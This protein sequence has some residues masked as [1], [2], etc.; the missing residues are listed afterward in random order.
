MG[1]KNNI[2]NIYEYDNK[3]TKKEQTYQKRNL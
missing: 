3:K 1:E 2:N